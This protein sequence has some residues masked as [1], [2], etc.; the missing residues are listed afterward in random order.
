MKWGTGV[1]VGVSPFLL[2]SIVVL[3]KIKLPLMS[4]ESSETVT[5][6]S[7]QSKI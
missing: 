4:K 1:G 7:R 5:N 3:L 2:G 6:T